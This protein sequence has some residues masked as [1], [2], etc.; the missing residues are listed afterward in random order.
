MPPPPLGSSDIR[1]GN[2]SAPTKEPW[3]THQSRGVSQ[4]GLPAASGYCARQQKPKGAP[5]AR[6]PH[7]IW[8]GGTSV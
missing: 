4:C 3:R 8:L 5:K 6:Q 7:V 2:L 1:E